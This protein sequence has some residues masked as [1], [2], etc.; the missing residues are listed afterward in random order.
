MVFVTKR[1][2]EL[3]PLKALLLL[4]LTD[5][6]LSRKSFVDYFDPLI[7]PLSRVPK[8]EVEGVVV[9]LSSADVSPAFQERSEQS[10]LQ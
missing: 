9:E 2:P 3:S 5:R 4:G 10:R 1:S 7:A 8:V 6:L